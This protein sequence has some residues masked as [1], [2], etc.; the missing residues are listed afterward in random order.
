M[1]A[2]IF[3]LLT[4]I[5]ALAFSA[6]TWLLLGRPEPMCHGC[7]LPKSLCEC[8]GRGRGGGERAA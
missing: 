4:L 3:S 2:F 7:D 8:E 6:L 1:I 5:G